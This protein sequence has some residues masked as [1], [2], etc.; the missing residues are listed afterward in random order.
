[1]S[2]KAP[3]RQRVDHLFSQNRPL[4]ERL[5][6]I[7]AF[8]QTGP[9]K[10]PVQQMDKKY[11]RCAGT[12]QKA[13]RDVLVN[14]ACEGT[15]VTSLLELW[16]VL[17]MQ[18]Q[19][20][21][22]DDKVLHHIDQFLS[23]V[24]SHEAAWRAAPPPS[25]VS[26]GPALPP[27]ALEQLASI[28][29]EACGGAAAHGALPNRLGKRERE[30]AEA[31]RRATERAQHQGYPSLPAS[32]RLDGTMCYYCH[33]RFPSRMAL[34]AHLRRVIDRDRFIEGHHQTHFGLRVPGGPAALGSGPYVCAGANCGKTFSGSEALWEHYCKM[35]V[36]G[37]EQL[38]PCHENAPAAA[39]VE[40]APLQEETG[41]PQSA[42]A[43][44]VTAQND[45]GADLSRC[46]V[47]LDKPPDVVMVPCGH[48]YACEKCGKKLKECALCRTP[49]TQVL[50]VY[51]SSEPNL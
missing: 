23:Y 15:G 33:R 38:P 4:L 18:R 43:G 16:G 6:Y 51:Y 28:G 46:S 22:E 39:V 48:I 3:V 1:M 17:G 49:V 13:E 31:Q 20:D 32:R 26:E 10:L 45:G 50:R 21:V 30:L 37:F 47:C 8:F 42:A 27:A 19:Q 36:P 41:P 25:D 34:F 2:A 11:A 44:Y 14:A 40:A 12:V 7:M 9:G 35:G 24:Q 5:T 29:A